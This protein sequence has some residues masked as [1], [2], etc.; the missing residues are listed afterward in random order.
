M[1]FRGCDE[2]GSGE[3]SWEGGAVDEVDGA[4]GLTAFWLEGRI[5]SEGS[6]VFK[7]IGC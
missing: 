3:A 7:A 6:L 4:G 1:A 5:L 2:A